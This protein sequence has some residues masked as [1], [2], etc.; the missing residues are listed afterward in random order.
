VVSAYVIVLALSRKPRTRE[1]ADSGI[2]F[3]GLVAGVALT[4]W[5]LFFSGF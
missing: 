2:F 4:V 1:L 3:L 5:W